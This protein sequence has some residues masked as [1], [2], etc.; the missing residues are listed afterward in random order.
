MQEPMPG[1]EGTDLSRTNGNLLTSLSRFVNVALSS[2]IPV[3]AV[4][5][6]YTI[7]RLP[8]RLYAVAGFSVVF[9]LT[10]AIFTT[11]RPIEIFTATAA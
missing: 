5:V 7:E 8:N 11:A 2:L 6:L 4:L 3:M 9:S 1:A 10:L